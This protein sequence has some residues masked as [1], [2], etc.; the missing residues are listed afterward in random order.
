MESG[1][2][3]KEP[4]PAPEIPEFLPYATAM[5]ELFVHLQAQ[6]LPKV[7][8]TLFGV[9]LQNPINL[10]CLVGN[11][12]LAPGALR[13]DPGFYASKLLKKLL[14]AVRALD[15]ELVA[16]ILAHAIPPVGS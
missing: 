14:A 12:E 15:W 11:A 6:K 16:D 4:K 7:V 3:V 5:D 1:A 10:R 13:V 9:A 2:N 8:H